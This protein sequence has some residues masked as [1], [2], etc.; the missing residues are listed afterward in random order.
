MRLIY[1]HLQQFNQNKLVF[2][3]I[4]TEVQVYRSRYMQ[5]SRYDQP[6]GEEYD[7]WKK[8]LPEWLATKHLNVPNFPEPAETKPTE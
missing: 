4:K 7:L 1:F 3:C 2:F 5:K 6:Q 8:Q